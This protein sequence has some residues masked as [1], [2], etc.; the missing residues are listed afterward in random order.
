[1]HSL[2]K[3]TVFLWSVIECAKSANDVEL[4]KYTTE[5]MNSANRYLSEFADA[6]QDINWSNE[7]NGINED[8]LKLNIKLA[9]DLKAYIR[10]LNEVLARIDVDIIEDRNLRRQLKKIPG[11][12]YDV[13]GTEEL[14]E[15]HNVTLEMADI[16]KTVGLCSYQDNRICNLTL[17]PHVQDIIHKS[18][19]IKEIEYYWLEWR[20][21]TGAYVRDKFQRFVELY[22]KT[23]FL[24]GKLNYVLLSFVKWQLVY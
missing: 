20:I 1:M 19:D 17:I 21:K 6:D 22:R 24:N 16:Y 11:L 8:N 3:I 9:A 7:I 14:N 23:A 18:D 15:L 13:L 12:G 4:V 5:F 2:L 10:D